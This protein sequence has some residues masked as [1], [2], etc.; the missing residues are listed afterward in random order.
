MKVNQ[1][2]Y[3]HYHKFVK[4]YISTMCIERNV[5]FTWV[6]FLRRGTFDPE[7]LTAISIMF[8][9]HAERQIDPDYNFQIVGLETGATPIV[10][11]ISLIAK[12]YLE[13]DINAFVVRKDVKEY[14]SVTDIEGLLNDKPVLILDDLCNTAFSMRRCY[15]VV[16]SYD[17]PVLPKV[18]SIVNVHDK[19][20]YLPDHDM[21]S[22]YTLE[23]FDLKRPN[24]PS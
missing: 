23:D 20:E 11:G 24:M 3:D 9:Y 15:D 22:L 4:D 12:L 16:K 8:L 13:V 6:M 5:G 21:I 2:M 1:D 19:L 7:F 14:G 18:F 17:L 10:T